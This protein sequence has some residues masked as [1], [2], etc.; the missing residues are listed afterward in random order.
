M[1]KTALPLHNSLHLV[2]LILSE[3]YPWLDICITFIWIYMA[4]NKTIEIVGWCTH[5]LLL[6]YILFVVLHNR[7]SWE[8]I[9]ASI[10]LF[11]IDVIHNGSN[12]HWSHNIS[13]PCNQLLDLLLVSSSIIF[14]LIRIV[15][16]IK[17]LFQASVELHLS[18]NILLILYN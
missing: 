18:L 1:Q 8:K 5:C 9:S 17:C 2:F 10:T 13:F 4:F 3:D 7:R 6:A 16:N 11:I 14:D 12:G 15:E